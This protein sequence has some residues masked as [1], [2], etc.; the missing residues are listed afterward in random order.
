MLARTLIVRAEKPG[1]PLDVQP[2]KSEHQTNRVRGFTLEGE[3]VVVAQRTSKAGV[4]FNKLLGGKVY[5]VAADACAPVMEKD[6]QGKPT[7]KQKTEDGAL[8]YSCSG[9]YCLS[10]KDYPA[11][12]LSCP[13]A[14]L[15]ERGAKALLLSPAQLQGR[16]RLRLEDCDLDLELLQAELEQA[17][18]D[19]HCLVRGHDDAVNRKRR[20]AIDAARAE[21]EDQG[22]A[23]A[24]VDFATLSSSP[25]DGN[26][27][28][29]YVWEGEHDAGSGLVLREQTFGG[30]K[31]ATTEYYSAEQAVALFRQSPAWERLERALE[32]G[33]VEFSFVRGNLMR[34]SISFRRKCEQA[35]APGSAASF[36]DAAFIRGA[37]A[38]WV[39]SACAILYSQHPLFPGKDYD[40]LHYV[41]AL[42]Q[43]EMG[44]DRH[45]DRWGTPQPIH[46]DIRGWLAKGEGGAAVA[47][48]ASPGAAVARGG[49][50]LAPAAAR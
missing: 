4:D 40:S 43:A 19:A 41:A 8:L 13:W 25:K 47:G 17:L 30:E 49:A 26:P 34:T 46:Y 42:R 12:E 20:R 1:K 5:A 7:K 37:A 39:R 10:S 50:G 27:F 35:L 32:D 45:E 3:P 44:L 29:M 18:D 36:G 21:A 15:L 16:K 33:S 9:F 11:L 14:L 22:E 23:Y 6:D 2:A 24:G 28:V 38:G 48:S 31:F